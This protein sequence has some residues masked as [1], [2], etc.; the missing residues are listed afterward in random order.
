[1]AV[2]LNFSQTWALYCLVQFYTATK[3]K[4]EPIKPLSKFLTFKSII[5]LTW[6]QG[7]AVAFLFSTGLFNGHLAQSL[8]TRIQD[9]IICLEVCFIHYVFFFTVSSLGLIHLL[10]LVFSASHLYA[11]STLI[12]AC[13]IHAKHLS[14]CYMP[15]LHFFHSR[16][17][18]LWKQVSSDSLHYRSTGLFMHIN[19]ITS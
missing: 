11:L 8:Q 7:I 18:L 1:M 17:S 6:W 3:E 13:R 16:C 14:N 9:Y 19:L 2:V 5:F 15:M 12:G 10:L 4:L